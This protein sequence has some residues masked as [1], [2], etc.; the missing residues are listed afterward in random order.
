MLLLWA[1]KEKLSSYQP[2]TIN[3]QECSNNNVT[4]INVSSSKSQCSRREALPTSVKEEM[5]DKFIGMALLDYANF[6]EPFRPPKDYQ[7]T[8]CNQEH[9]MVPSCAPGVTL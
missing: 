7:V 4:G 3:L 6:T 5:R 9:E 8:Q 2:V 1:G